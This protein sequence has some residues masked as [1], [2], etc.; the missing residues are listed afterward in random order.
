MTSLV[1]HARHTMRFKTMSTTIHLGL[2]V[3][4]VLTNCQHYVIDLL[5]FLQVEGRA[6]RGKYP[7]SA[8]KPHEIVALDFKET[9]KLRA[10]E[11]LSFSD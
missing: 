2:R 5:V 4:L 1:T 10:L 11:N 7:E 9:V 6:V 8:V 3:S